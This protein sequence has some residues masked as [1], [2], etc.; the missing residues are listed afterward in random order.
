MVSTHGEPTTKQNIPVFPVLCVAV[1]LHAPTS[2]ASDSS[3][4]QWPECTF[5]DR[6]DSNRS[7]RLKEG[8]TSSDYGIPLLAEPGCAT[9]ACQEGRKLIRCA[10]K[11]NLAKFHPL[12]G[13]RRGVCAWA[14]TESTGASYSRFMLC[15]RACFWCYP[16]SCRRPREGRKGSEGPLTIACACQKESVLCRDL[17]RAKSHNTRTKRSLTP[18]ILPARFW[19][20]TIIVKINRKYV[21]CESFFRGRGS[22]RFA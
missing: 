20:T 15:F 3:F 14:E 12:S 11:S 8:S 1:T 5:L 2:P 18:F 4:P 16:S 9:L 6:S 7:M 21:H 10:S 22:V 13:Y 19:G 17:H